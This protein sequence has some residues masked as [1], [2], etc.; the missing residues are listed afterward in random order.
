MDGSHFWNLDDKVASDVNSVLI[1][2]GTSWLLHRKLTVPVGGTTQ[3]S[4]NWTTSSHCGG[5]AY[6]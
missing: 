1:H 2:I 5:M 6:T 4:L 3:K